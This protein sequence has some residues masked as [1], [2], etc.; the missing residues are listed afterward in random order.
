MTKPRILFLILMAAVLA[1]CGGGGDPVVINGDELSAA[2]IEKFEKRYG[3]K[4]APGEYWYDRRSGLYGNS[5]GPAAGFMHPGHDY[6][7]LSA[8]ASGGGT[9]VFVNGRELPPQEWASWSMLFGSAVAP[10]R[11]WLD[12][13]ASYG[14]E[15]LNRP[16]GN[17]LLVLAA[18]IRAGGGAGGAKDN[19]WVSRFSAGNSTADGSAGYVSVPGIGPVGYG[20]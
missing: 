12:E 11:Y 19:F 20:F 6:G 16:L 17:L 3:A 4:P 10:G 5:G 1:S 8:G 9:D 2:Q 7:E 18:R 14:V 13:T 15:G